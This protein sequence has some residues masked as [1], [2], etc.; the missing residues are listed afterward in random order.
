M[1]QEVQ[2][3][4]TPSIEA[5]LA[6]NAAQELDRALDA[7]NAV[8]PVPEDEAGIAALVG[9]LVERFTIRDGPTVDE[10]ALRFRNERNQL[11]VLELPISGR[12][13]WLAFQVRSLPPPAFVGQVQLHTE[14]PAI[15]L[16]YKLKDPTKGWEGPVD[17]DMAML[18]TYIGALTAAIAAFNGMLPAMVEGKIKDLLSY[19]QVRHDIAAKLAKRG[20]QEGS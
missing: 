2:F 11:L 6:T 7:L 9:Q 10:A 5:F 16:T 17:G 15:V 19:N 1:S 12:G 14:P 13:E 3:F 18:R 4:K 8:G 20:F